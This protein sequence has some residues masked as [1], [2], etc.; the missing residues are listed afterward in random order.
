MADRFPLPYKFDVDREL[1]FATKTV[2]F[3]SN[4]KQVQQLSINPISTWKINIKGTPEQ[5]DILTRFFNA[6]GGNTKGFIFIDE[7]GNDVTVR[8]AEPKLTTKIIRNFD[9]GSPTRGYVVGF[10]ATVTLESVL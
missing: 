7:N 6:Q 10:D 9:V 1:T 8:F 2:V 5:L 4:K 3:N